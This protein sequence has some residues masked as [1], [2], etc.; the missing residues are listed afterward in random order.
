MSSDSTKPVKSPNYHYYIIFKWARSLIISLFGGQ[1][2]S[3]PIDDHV[4]DPH[5]QPHTRTFDDLR[6]QRKS[7]VFLSPHQLLLQSSFY[8]AHQHIFVDTGHSRTLFFMVC[9]VGLLA[10]S[11]FEVSW[12]VHSALG[13]NLI[14]TGLFCL[15]DRSY[16]CLGGGFSFD[17][18]LGVYYVGCFCLSV[19]LYFETWSFFVFLGFCVFE[20]PQ[21]LNLKSIVSF[22]VP[23]RLI[24]GHNWIKY[25]SSM[26]LA[27]KLFLD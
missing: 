3:D 7:L 27:I 16:F 8:M 25:I 15:A 22:L 12:V 6:T 17:V 19:L 24:L 2:S 13:L 5:I 20:Q 9:A 4:P 14:W 26:P 11:Y 1:H 18:F 23:L 10:P 21:P